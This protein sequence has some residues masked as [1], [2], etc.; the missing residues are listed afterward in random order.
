MSIGY[1][2][3]ILLCS[4]LDLRFYTYLPPVPP[5]HPSSRT[6]IVPPKRNTSSF[7]RFIPARNTI[8]PDELQAHTGMFGGKTND[9]YYDL[10]LATSTIIREAVSRERGYPEDGQ[11]TRTES[12]EEPPEKS[13]EDP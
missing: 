8:A 6:F 2:S 9:G 4:S 7:S 3:Y 13:D 1:P 10:G 11:N 5:V 12:V